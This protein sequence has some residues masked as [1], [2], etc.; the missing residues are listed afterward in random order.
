MIDYIKQV[1][2][3]EILLPTAIYIF[4]ENNS[5]IRKEGMIWMHHVKKVT[6]IFGVLKLLKVVLCILGQLALELVLFLSPLFLDPS[7]GSV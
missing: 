5:E 3:T 1:A 2:Y 7:E 6:C 4:Q